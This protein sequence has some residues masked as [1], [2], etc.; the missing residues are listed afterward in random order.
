MLLLLCIDATAQKTPRHNDLVALTPNADKNVQLLD[1]Y[2]DDLVSGN[3]ERAKAKLRPDYTEYGPGASESMNLNQLTESWERAAH[4]RT[5]QSISNRTTLSFQSKSGTDQGEWVMSRGVYNWRERNGGPVMSIPF[6]VT[7]QVVDGKLKN[8]YMYF[9][10]VSAQDKLG[11]TILSSDQDPELYL[12]KKVIED[13]TSA[14][15][16]NDGKQMQSCWADLSYATHTLT[17]ESGKAY[18]VSGPEMSDQIAR[19]SAQ[20]PNEPGITFSNTRYEVRP[21]GSAAW[22]TFEQ[23]FQKPNGERYTNL[24]SRY[25]EKLGG[26][27]KIVHM[28]TLPKK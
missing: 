8:T 16:R 21:N 12:I 22:V 27:W 6:Q 1:S 25:L 11:Y 19:L 20:K 28:T 2:L 13:E 17:D 5:E 24:E 9:N 4:D 26:N 18:V 15:L 3:F 23:T 14:W 7:A 10:R